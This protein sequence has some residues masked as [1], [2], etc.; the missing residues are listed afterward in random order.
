MAISLL[1]PLFERLILFIMHINPKS[2]FLTVGLGIAAVT[3]QVRAS[4]LLINGNFTGGTAGWTITGE[5]NNAEWADTKGAIPGLHSTFEDGATDSQGYLWHT[6]NG[7][8]FTA[9]QSVTVGSAGDFVLSGQF[10]QRDDAGAPGSHSNATFTLS[11]L[12]V[13]NVV[14]TP[15]STSGSFPGDSLTNGTAPDPAQTVTRS[16]TNLPA[17]TYRV[18]Y[19]IAGGQGASD[20]LSLDSTSSSITTPITWG[21]AT[22]IAGDSDVSTTGTFKYAYHWNTGD[23][24]V[25]GV[26]F[27]G[28]TSYTAGGGD[29]DLSNFYANHPDF[30]STSAPFVNLTTAY[31]ATLSGS[32]YNQGATVTVTL[33][34]LTIGNSYAVQVWMEDART[35]GS[36]RT[37]TLTSSGGNSVVLDYNSTDADGG[38]GQYSIGTF[39]AYSAT[40]NFTIA[41]AGSA[42]LN[43]LQVRDLAAGGSPYDTWANGTFVNPFTAKLPTEDPDGDGQTNQQEFAFGLD[44]TTG[45][46][47]N[48]IT[49]QLNKAAKTFSY[50]RRDTSKTDLT[51]SVWFSTDLSAW[52]ED[53]SA[54]EG[55][56][57]LNG[58]VE[59]VQVTLSNLL[60]H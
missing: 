26:T 32:P 31:K 44:P 18:Q 49:V 12:D 34:N 37:A 41:A 17:G 27:T 30:T 38:V 42:Q 19:T 9:T 5:T 60:P 54:A 14:L 52:T 57:V 36:G 23:Q 48:P 55:T 50:T 25:N 40:Q 47:V 11:L 24:T 1:F 10:Q 56:P 4:E 28:T 43:A 22:T 16:Y 45:S 20:T 46:S 6:G 15:N 59:T 51:Y 29:V 13:G 2:K 39:T 3:A 8:G 58:E 53:T 33:K 21:T 7:S 35:A